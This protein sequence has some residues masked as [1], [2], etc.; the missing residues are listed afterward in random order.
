MVADQRLTVVY[1]ML[2]AWQFFRQRIAF[3]EEQLRYFFGQDYEDYAS[4][5]LIRIPLLDWTFA[6][7][8]ASVLMIVNDHGWLNH[9]T[10]SGQ[11][12]SHEVGDASM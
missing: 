8:R 2:Q 3:E 6:D 4:K 11:I 9:V 7:R 5:V 1:W 12:T 10:W